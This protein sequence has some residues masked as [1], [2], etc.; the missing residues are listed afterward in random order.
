[1]DR[2]KGIKR[3]VTFT[4]SVYAITYL[5][6]GVYY[7]AGGRLNQPWFGAVAVLYMW[8]PALTAIMHGTMNA[9]AGLSIL[10][11]RRGGDLIIG[12]T[13]LAGAISLALINL[14]IY[15][16]DRCYAAKPV[17]ALYQAMS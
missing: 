3:A 8:L 11:V 14:G 13:G 6:A 2:P 12:I 4:A 7:A 1:M 5:V 17:S 9:V 10:F 15:V 16:C